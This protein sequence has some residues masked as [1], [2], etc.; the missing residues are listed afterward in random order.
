MDSRVSLVRR[1]GASVL[2]RGLLAL[3]ALSGCDGSTPPPS[4]GLPNPPPAGEW[5][6]IE[7]AGDTICSRGTD[8]RFFVRGGRSDRVMIDFQGGGACW[9][10][11]TCGAAGALD[12]FSDDV[13]TLEQFTGWVEANGQGGYLSNDPNNPFRDWTIVHIPY[14]TGDIHWGNTRTEYGEDLAIE[15][16][17][18]VNA[19]AALDWTYAR[20]TNPSH[21]FVSGCSAGAYGAVLHSAYVANHYASA[22]VSVFADSGAGI[23]TDSFLND[24][25]PNWNA[26]PNLPSF[27]PG[28]DIP[29]SELSL[30]DLYIRIGQRFPAM[31]LAQTNTNYDQDQVFFYTAMGGMAADWPV[32]MR[33]SHDRIAGATSNFT[34]YVPGGSVHCAGIYP[35]LQERTVDGVALV[36][37][38]EQ[39]ATG[40]TM[41]ERVV[42]EGAAC[43]D[44]AVCEECAA[45]PEADRATY[46]Q[47]CRDWPTAWP[48]CSGT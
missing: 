15:H 8:Y 37:W 27:V 28:L 19:T 39:L 24:S 23:I 18:F 2:P 46:C 1:I 25:L 41:P 17:G 35:I 30:A 9:D 36:D 3:G 38:A 33:A 48:E 34:S 31:R 32:E 7:P 20:F 40:D 26:Q 45:T 11:L 5:I 42:C 14:C 44:D 43:C 22:R 4:D 13:G 21:V 29:L 10:E 6:A 47:F 12:L 16:R